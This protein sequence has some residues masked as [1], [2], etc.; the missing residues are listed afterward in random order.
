MVL[1]LLLSVWV[2]QTSGCTKDTD[3]KGERIC[4]AGVCVAPQQSAAPPPPPPTPPT[5]ENAASYPRVVRRDG[6]TCVQSLDDAGRVQEAC[7]REDTSYGRP[8]PLAAGG[9]RQAEVEETPRARQP[10]VTEPG[11]RFVLDAL[12]QGG[13]T[14]L[15]APG[16]LGALPQVSGTVA[17]GARFRAGIGVQGLV[18]LS[19]SFRSGFSAIAFTVAPALRFGNQSH[20]TLALGPSVLGSSGSSGTGIVGSLIAQSVFAVGDSFVLAIQAALHAD[21]SGVLFMLGAGFGFGVL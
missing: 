21:A 5:V 3:C 10:Q 11:A 16:I 15:T 1:S 19:G 9:A 14:I 12:L 18:N 8:R 20:F 6:L 13:L 17:L 7:R 4:E 2:A